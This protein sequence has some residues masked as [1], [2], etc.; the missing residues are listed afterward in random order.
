MSEKNGG[1]DSGKEQE[2]TE[3]SL[4]KA[5][6][7]S[8]RRAQLDHAGACNFTAEIEGTPAAGSGANEPRMGDTAGAE[9]L[10]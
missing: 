10:L 2:L 8:A 3:A 5:S 7:G 9:E 6:G 4:E 1:I